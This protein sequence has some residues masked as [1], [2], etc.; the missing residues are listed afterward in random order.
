MY[1]F[2]VI[3]GGIVGVATAREILRRRPGARLV[4]LEKEPGLAAHQTGHNSGVIHS[5]IYYAPGS[6][7]AQFCKAGAAETKEF[8]AEHRIPVEVCGKLLVATSEAEVARM[9]ALEERA[10]VNGIAVPRLGAAELREREPP[11]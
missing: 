1:D 4:L 7:K 11:E 8:A 10:A 6:L 5:G 2:G 9:A 3:G